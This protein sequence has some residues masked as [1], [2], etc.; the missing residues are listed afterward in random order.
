MT[1]WYV[2]LTKPKQERRAEEH[3]VAQGGEVFLPRLQ[4]E[5]IRK[6]KR[7]KV[8]ESLYTNKGDDGIDQL[9]MAC[10]CPEIIGYSAYKSSFSKKIMSSALKW[11]GEDGKRDVFSASYV[12]AFAHEDMMNAV[13]ILNGHVEWDA[14]KKSQ[15]LLCFPRNQ[16]TFALV[17]ELDQ[18]GRSLYWTKLNRYFVSNKDKELV[19][20][21]AARF[22]EYDR[23]LAALDAISQVFHSSD[24]SQLDGNLVES[25]LIK[26]ATD[27]KDL[28][29]PSV[30][31]DQY[32]IVKGI[33]FVQD[34]SNLE[35]DKIRQ[36]EWI[37]MQFF[38]F[39][40][41]QPRYLFKYVTENP[42]FFAQLVSWRF[43][44]ND[45]REDDAEELSQE[46]QKQRTETVWELL[47]TLS[48]LPGVTGDD[49]DK[50][51]L[52]SWVDIARTVFKESGRVG[53]G[54]SQIG[55]FLA[56]SQVGKGEV[57]PHESVRDVIERIKS[58]DIENGMEC[59]RISAR[60]VT[61]RH[62][63]AGGSQ[64]RNLALSYRHDAEKIQ[65]IWP[66]TAGILR[67]IAGNYDGW[68]VREDQ[69]VEIGH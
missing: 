52:N 6:G 49:I 60:G 22:L 15:F 46:K 24:I 10:S 4:L 3:L 35:L 8:I 25:I 31:V 40:E 55:S 21:I 67:S 13:D 51:I 53:I 54:D 28:N 17:D 36:L 57:W 20:I 27:P 37:Y 69:N 23:P 66:R 43:K 30:R 59:G 38:R 5:K 42:E 16:E 50:D 33:E 68:A 2:V 34:Y 11:L 65:L 62:P 58:E 1:K 29:S 44:R 61:T 32:K 12:S 18:A 39:S 63:Y 9:I 19:S 14:E 7:I 48:M 47:D 56:R 45:N 41:V 64:E 26:I